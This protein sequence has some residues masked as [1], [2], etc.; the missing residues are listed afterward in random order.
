MPPLRHFLAA[1]LL[2]ACAH[3]PLPPPPPSAAP[4]PTPPPALTPPAAPAASAAEPAPIHA[5]ATEKPALLHEGILRR[6]SSGFAA[7]C[8]ESDL[9]APYRGAQPPRTDDGNLGR[10]LALSLPQGTVIAR[11]AGTSDIA[12]YLSY[13]LDPS[14]E[15]GDAGYRVMVRGRDGK[16]RDGSLGFSMLRP[17]V[18]VENDKL[19]LLDGDTLQLAVDVR[20]IDDQSIT[21]PPVALRARREAKDR[22]L[23]CPLT[24]VFQD[25]DGDG[26]TDVDEARLTTDPD[27][28]DTDGDGLPDGTDPAPL[29]AEPPKTPEDEVRVAA[30]KEIVAKDVGPQLLITSGDGSRID[31]RGVPFRVLELR[32]DEFA[33]YEKR[34]GSRVT[35]GMTV[36]VLDSERAQVDVDYGW[37]GVSFV[38][39][40]HGAAG[41]WRFMRSSEWITRAGELASPLRSAMR[42]PAGGERLPGT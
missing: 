24:S 37:R 23:R 40:R 30:F 33:A 19:P 26:A 29:G 21:F 14:S 18:V 4:L 31:L 2:P 13:K 5:A 36:K 20:E 11:H 27:D 32:T 34:F 39:T 16:T 9:P 42:A 22:M 10:G 6:L 15:V 38:A 25:T 17:Y 28:P 3:A 41:R 7:P 35:F 12:V 1:F 8:A